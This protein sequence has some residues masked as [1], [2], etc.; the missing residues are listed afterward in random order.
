MS[1]KSLP[2]AQRAGLA[3]A[4]RD[5]GL[6]MSQRQLQSSRT[7]IPFSRAMQS[8]IPT[9]TAT[10]MQQNASSFPMAPSTGGPGSAFSFGGGTP[11]SAGG[12]SDLDESPIQLTPGPGQ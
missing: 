3:S 5:A 4:N 6:H 9:P 10:P 2:L 1:V 8:G 7:P 12:Y 11:N